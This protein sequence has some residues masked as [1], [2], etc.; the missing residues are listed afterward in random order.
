MLIWSPGPDLGRRHSTGELP[1][2]QEEF[3]M[4][5]SRAYL[6]AARRSAIGRIGGLHRSRRI[7]AL[8][9]PVLSAALADAN[10]S[11][12]D[13]EEVMLGNTSQGGNPARLIALAAGCAETATAVTVDRQ[14]G[15]G[16]D[17]ILAAIRSID[18]GEADIVVAGG[19]EALSTAPWRIAKPLSLYQLPRFI[20]VDA[21]PPT[22]AHE[23]MAF[24]A[25][26]ELAR[27]LGIS[28][29]IQDGLALK[30]HL[31]ALQAR[32]SKWSKDEIVPLKLTAEETRD[33]SVSDPDLE[34]V[35][36]ETPFEP[37]GGTLT[38]ANTSAPHDG[39]A[40]AVIVSDVTHARL[41]RPPAL[42]LTASASLG[43][44]P[45]SEAEAPIHAARKLYGKLNGFDRSAISIFEL[46]ETSAAQLVAFARELGIDPDVVNLEGGQVARGHPIGASGAV[47]VT[48][49]FSQ[50]IRCAQPGAPRHGMA[51]QGAVGG[52]GLAALFSAV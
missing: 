40:F 10:L 52:L 30:S 31:R 48:R 27:R 7:D 16:L 35:A 17:A 51:V 23:T 22:D 39:C 15:S 18:A 47:L 13:V 9:A 6:I 14:C 49:L 2:L 3:V 34:D 20:G 41:G 25:Q 50:M 43:V 5:E 21:S 32:E 11:A 19:A 42:K 46:A 29:E 44:G 4:R 28:R 8:A 1:Q 45:L 24:A 37:E 33:Q 26:E 12:S 38:P 36:G